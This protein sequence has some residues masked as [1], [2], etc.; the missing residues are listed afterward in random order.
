MAKVWILE[1]YITAE[2]MKKSIDDLSEMY[3]VAEAK[4]DATDRANAIKLVDEM[5]ECE[6]KTLDKNPNGYWLAYQGKTNYRTF[7]EVAKET[8]RNLYGSEFRVGKADIEDNSWTWVG[9][10]N[11][12]QNDGVLRYLYATL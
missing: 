12:V 9:Y 1:R 7:C 4:E 6:R 5:I 11:F 3:K 10:K 2:D 8:M